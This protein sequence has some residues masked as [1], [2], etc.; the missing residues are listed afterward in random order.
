MKIMW[1]RRENT[2]Q[3]G[4]FFADKLKYTFRQLEELSPDSLFALLE[5]I[6]DGDLSDIG[7]FSDNENEEVEE[8][9]NFN[10]EELD[11]VFAGDELNRDAEV[12]QDSFW[13][14]ED[15]IPLSVLR[16]NE[17]KKRTIWTKDTKNCKGKLKEFTEGVGPTIPPGISTPTEMFLHIFPNDLIDHIVFQTNLY[18]LQKSGG[19]SKAFLPTNSNEVKTFLGV[20]LLMG[21]KRLP[22]YRDY[23]S[24]KLELR[25]HYIGSV[26]SRDRFAWLLGHMHINDNAV[27][28]PRST[29]NF[30]KLYKIRPLL[31]KLAE[32]FAT[33]Y[34][35]SEQ[36]AI[37]ESMIR[38]KGRSAL[39]QYMPLKPI[40]RG[41]KVWIRADQYGFVSQFQ[42]YTGKVEDSVE[43]KLGS[44]VV[45][46]LTRPLVGK[47][48]T[49]YFD[50]FFNSIEL[51]KS[52][53][54]DMIFSCG[55]ARKGRKGLP[56]DIKND[57]SL[58]R[59]ESDW[60]VISDGIVFMK[61]KD[62]KG[63]LFLDN[64]HDPSEGT[65][66]SRKKKDGTSEEIAC[67]ILVRDYNIHM[68][69]V[70]KMDMLK[71]IYETDR[72][73]KKWWH[74]IFFYFVD[75]ALLNSFIIFKLRS[76]GKSLSLKN[77]RLSVAVGL[78]GAVRNVPQRG[79]KSE[80]PLHA[81]NNFKPTVPLEVRFD[82]CAHMPIHGNPRR[83]A[84][85]ST[86]NQPHRSKWA[87]TTC[88]VGLCLNDK[89]NCFIPYHKK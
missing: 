47:G 10:I 9:C 72:K 61:W 67:P 79:R 34:K 2:R 52:L 65:T 69:Y 75:V 33:S 55:T 57:N 3:I 41:Y 40:K 26:I 4:A 63:V 89:K 30:D 74:R 66:T 73:S 83:C 54:S 14:E 43:K 51:Q 19:D 29:E 80:E 71:S 68:G 28:P 7:D 31:D 84:H 1:L 23:W 58:Q 22:S 18:A 42:I 39:R 17:L 64:F 27:Q 44:R 62:R 20:N 5:E 50:N 76:T 82:Q 12:E 48:Y 78:I 59:G 13:D 15:E 45:T 24:S 85:C 87:C 16:A 56:S 53:L 8:N 70:D 60:R 21:I 88:N 37:D 86:R 77:F 36:Q 38:F 49:V 11:I 35:P 81:A 32:T 46:D 25:D 6:P